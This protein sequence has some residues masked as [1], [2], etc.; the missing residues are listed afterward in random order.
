VSDENQNERE[1]FQ[2][3][4]DSL[5]V[6]TRTLVAEVD[7]GRQV[8]EFFRSELGRYLLGCA[9]FEYAEAMEELERTSSW[10]RR[11]IRDLQNQ[12]WRARSFIEW[13]R[14]L[15]IAGK[16]AENALADREE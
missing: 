3:L 11:R 8:P 2:E 12:A 14:G 5:D 10:R 6:T 7:L 16:S 13:L 4:L 1:A 9:Q 15:I